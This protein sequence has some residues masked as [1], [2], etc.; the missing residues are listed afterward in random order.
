MH[1][2]KGTQTSGAALNRIGHGRKDAFWGASCQ[3]G[4]ADPHSRHQNWMLLFSDSR[5][6]L[7]CCDRW[8]YWV[9]GKRETQRM[10][11][12]SRNKKQSVRHTQW[13]DC[14][15]TGDSSSG[16]GHFA[17]QLCF[18]QFQHTAGED[19]HKAPATRLYYR[20]LESH[21]ANS[22]NKCLSRPS[23]AP[24]EHFCVMLK[25]PQGSRNSRLMYPAPQ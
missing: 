15:N 24:R 9:Q 25:V 22:H 11:S 18:T 19:W 10:C 6:F 4:S 12:P 23:T 8:V 20:W 5:R 17:C 16:E 1:S 14:S 2:L 7:H 3:A 13:E 21:T